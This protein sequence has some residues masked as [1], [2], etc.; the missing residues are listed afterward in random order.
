[1]GGGPPGSAFPRERPG[2]VPPPL[3]LP[4]SLPPGVVPPPPP[5]DFLARERGGRVPVGNRNP[6]AGLVSSVNRTPP[7]AMVR[8]GRQGGDRRER[9]MGRPIDPYYDSGDRY[10]RAQQPP[11]PWQQQPQQYFPLEHHGGAG[12]NYSHGR[13]DFHDYPPPPPPP[14]G[15][16]GYRQ[17]EDYRHTSPDPYRRRELA[18]ERERGRSDQPPPPYHNKSNVRE[19]YF[20]QYM[21]L[22]FKQEEWMNLSKV[23]KYLSFLDVPSEV[24]DSKRR[25]KGHVKTRMFEFKDEH[26]YTS[27]EAREW[28]RYPER[29]FEDGPEEVLLAM[30]KSYFDIFQRGD[31]SDYYFLNVGGNEVKG[32]RAIKEAGGQTPV[33]DLTSKNDQTNVVEDPRAGRGSRFCF[34]HYVFI[35]NFDE[36]K[37]NKSTPAPDA[38]EEETGDDKDIKAGVPLGEDK[39]GK[40]DQQLPEYKLENED[41][42]KGQWY[43]FDVNGLVGP[44]SMYT[45]REEACKGTIPWGMSIRRIKD[46]AYT[47]LKPYS[48][49]MG[50]LFKNP[51]ESESMP[52]GST[53]VTEEGFFVDEL[54]ATKE[55][56]IREK[57]LASDTNLCQIHHHSYI[58]MKQ[59]D[60]AI[61]EVRPLLMEKALKQALEEKGRRLAQ[62]K[63]EQ[64]TLAQEKLKQE[65]LEQERLEQERLAQERLEQDR[66]EQDRL[67]QDRLE[68]EK[69]EQEKLEQERL[70]QER[71]KR[72]VKI[73]ERK[74]EGA[75]AEDIKL[76][77]AALQDAEP[78]DV[79]PKKKKGKKRKLKDTDADDGKLEKDAKQKGAKPKRKQQRRVADIA[80]KSKGCSK[81][82]YA[83][84]GCR[85]CDWG[86]LKKQV[87]AKALQFK[88]GKGKSAALS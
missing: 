38:K 43:Y 80:D 24:V 79:K 88:K 53:N 21:G 22:K 84:L 27:D 50:D 69:L 1:M 46:H 5:P 20:Q 61:K 4:P 77:D 45:L 6:A 71:L 82:R 59:H 54:K 65:K 44:N 33:I 48:I 32:E 17:Q 86:K 41:I 63:L 18:R 78:R 51:G 12:V 9:D 29:M 16:Y 37:N 8:Q 15:A 14:R 36:E 85:G 67:E 47:L 40:S 76:Q 26:K 52:N 70:E 31:D 35:P 25:S 13:R 60:D 42:E 11:Q 56:Y 30:T 49:G 87:H 62:Q 3:P 2:Y 83:K 57:N 73:E 64:E 58:R 10:R 23:E 7:R 34:P 28:D 55:E 19:M 68:Q 81:C 39:I 72:E 75:A 74:L 66:L